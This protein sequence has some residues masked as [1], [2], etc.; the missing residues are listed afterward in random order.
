MLTFIFVKVLSKDHANSPD[1]VSLIDHPGRPQMN[2]MLECRIV[3]VICM[4]SLFGSPNLQVR[5]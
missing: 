4:L 1:D 5:L 3:P 2:R